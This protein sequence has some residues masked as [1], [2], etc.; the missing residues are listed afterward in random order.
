[1]KFESFLE[2][3]NTRQACR[4]FNDKPLDKQTV[5]QIAKTS[6]LAPSACNS[7]PWKLYCVTEIDKVKEVTKAVQGKVQNRFLDKAKAYICVADQVATLKPEAMQRFDRNHFVQY[8]VGEV[9]A[10]ITLAAE[11]MGVKSCIIG[12][13]NQDALKEAIGLQENERC[14]VVVALGYSDSPVRKKV[15]KDNDKVI[16]KM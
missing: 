13:V 6:T 2:L 4:D 5:Y 3:V 1:M 9:V 12:W 10:Y 7:Q 8:D 16:V 15:R 11:S 14:N